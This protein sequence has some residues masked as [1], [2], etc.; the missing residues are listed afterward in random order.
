VNRQ[1]LVLAYI[2]TFWILRGL[3]VLA[4]GLVFLA[5]KNRPGSRPAMAH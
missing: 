5:K 2:D 1:A 3:A 4:I